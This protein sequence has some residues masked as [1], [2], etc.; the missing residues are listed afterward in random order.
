MEEAY[1]TFATK[2]SASTLGVAPADPCL[3]AGRW[4]VRGTMCPALKDTGDPGSGSYYG[5][6]VFQDSCS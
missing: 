1:S 3:L 6:V 5:E 4:A 2:R